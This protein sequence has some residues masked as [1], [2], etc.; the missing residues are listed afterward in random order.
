MVKI[1]KR[2][3]YTHATRPG[4]ENTFLI[5][6]CLCATAL[7]TK[8][9]DRSA[10]RPSGSDVGFRKATWKLVIFTNSK[11]EENYWSCHDE[12]GLHVSF[13]PT[14]HPATPSPRRRSQC[15]RH[16]GGRMAYL[17]FFSIHLIALSEVALEK[18]R[19]RSTLCWMLVVKCPKKWIYQVTPSRC[20]SIKG[21]LQKQFEEWGFSCLLKL[22]FQQDPA[23]LHVDENG[24][25]SNPH[26]ISECVWGLRRAAA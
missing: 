3:Q 24:E 18:Q 6:L 9:K 7:D 17:N 11:Y 21:K 26:P 16:S 12:L 5:E 1:R 25:A 10:N 8:C 13:S 14:L 4:L 22:P 19:A 20:I 23:K 2:N 15:L